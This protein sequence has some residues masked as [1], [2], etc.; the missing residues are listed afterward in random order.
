MPLLDLEALRAAPLTRDPFTFTVVRN[1]VPLAQA[2]EIRVVF[3]NIA[4]SDR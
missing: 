1:A 4:V 3:Y 2:A